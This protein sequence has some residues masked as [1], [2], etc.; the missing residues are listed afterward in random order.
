[1]LKR[2]S[3]DAWVTGRCPRQPLRVLYAEVAETA[4]ILAERHGCG[5]AS[6]LVL[7]EALTAAGLLSA[8]LGSPTATVTLR[9]AYEGPAGEV[10]VEAGN[11]GA[12]RGG[13]EHKSLP[14][15]DERDP[16]DLAALTGP[17]AQVSILQSGSDGM[18]AS[19]AEFSVHDGGLREALQLYSQLTLRRPTLAALSVSAQ[20]PH[21]LDWA[22]G[23]LVQV[24]PGGSPELLDPLRGLFDD[25]TVS[26]R[27][28][29][30]ASLDSIRELLG[31]PH[32]TIETVHP[33]FFGCPCN[34]EDARN[35]FAAM[36]VQD[37]NRLRR[38]GRTHS[39]SCPLCGAE[40][41]FSPADF[42]AIIGTRTPPPGEEP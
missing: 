40:Y 28:S 35:L 26:E 31:L 22:C 3:D 39:V 27:L 9:V 17:S 41:A 37:L 10:T 38:M 6:T 21:G 4:R 2:R 13:A 29:V 19:Q 5:P 18:P 32:L 12:L 42:G 1:M 8:D 14:D 30:D 34:R 15:W 11:D 25:G 36:P 20:P 24:L 33:L 16:L 23:L 7:A